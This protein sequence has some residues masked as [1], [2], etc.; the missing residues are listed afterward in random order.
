MMMTLQTWEMGE[1]KDKLFGGV[2]VIRHPLFILKRPI[3]GGKVRVWF[4][5][6]LICVIFLLGYRV[7][8]FGK[9]VYMV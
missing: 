3:L 2:P 7:S 1:C 9:F 6:A 8:K 4:K 5:A